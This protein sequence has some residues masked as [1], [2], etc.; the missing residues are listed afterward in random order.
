MTGGTEQAATGARARARGIALVSVLWALAL[1][2][3]VVAG[4][5]AETVAGLTSVRAGQEQAR[6]RALADAAVHTA[7]ARLLEQIYLGG[8]EGG[9]ALPVDGTPLSLRF[10]EGEVALSVTDAGG[11]VDLNA[12]EPALLAGVLRRVGASE[13]EA[14]ALAAR[15]VDFRDL[16]D[17]PLPGG[18][19]DADYAAAGLPF[20]AKDAPFES[21]DELPQVLGISYALAARMKL[22]VTVMNGLPQ[23]D[24]LVA[25]VF[26]LEAVPGLTPAARNVLL[27]LRARLGGVFRRAERPVDNPF[28]GAST[29]ASYRIIASA[30][31]AGGARFTREAV[32]QIRGSGSPPFFLR[33]WATQLT[34]LDARGR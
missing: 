11:L 1:I 9:R 34:P 4:F 22:F 33:R 19:E 6:A 24:P 5:R 8:G 3:L 31:L 17:R 29:R 26:V 10:P 21:I 28:F 15:I 30:R 13:A 18:A 14:A 23:I 32:V 20:G 7:I 25:P 16:D 27:G 2:A 12:A